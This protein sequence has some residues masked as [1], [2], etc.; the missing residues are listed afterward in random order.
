M[1]RLNKMEWMRRTGIDLKDKYAWVAERDDEVF[2]FGWLHR[3]EKNPMRYPMKDVPVPAGLPDREFQDRWYPSEQSGRIQS[4]MSA[5]NRV[6]EGKAKA[7]LAMCKAKDETAPVKA[8]DWMM[9]F[10]YTGRIEKDGDALWF[11][12][13]DRVEV[14]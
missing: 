7:R 4:W 11:H 6:L 13:E 12:V 8:T 5:L 3:L 10:Y 1:K 9:S 14:K 2:F